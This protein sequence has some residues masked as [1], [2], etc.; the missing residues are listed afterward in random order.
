MRKAM[1]AVLGLLL[2][3]ATAD[4]NPC[5]RAFVRTRVIT[6]RVKVAQFVAVPFAV[7]SYAVGYRSAAAN[8]YDN[9]NGNGD[10]IRKLREEIRE[11]RALLLES[12]KGGSSGR[13]AG[14]AVFRKR[15]IGC[16]E[17]AVAKAK[18]NGFVLLAKG[19][20]AELTDRQALRVV[21]QVVT[22]AMPK[23]GPKLTDEELDAV[24]A[25]AEA[26]K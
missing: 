24:I 11:L 22:N 5:R 14:V 4:A 13:E 2:L 18:G 10:E 3:A 17:S 6:Q 7:P 25:W 15:C 1:L 20:P 9:G 16:H 8:G 21:T 12:K 26:R 23:G 19:E